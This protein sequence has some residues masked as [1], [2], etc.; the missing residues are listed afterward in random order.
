MQECFGKV[1]TKF[2]VIIAIINKVRGVCPILDGDTCIKTTGYLKTQTMQPASV[3]EKN[4]F[5]LGQVNA[6][7]EHI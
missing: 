1:P 5:P 4:G 2:Q 7:D 3:A 6:S